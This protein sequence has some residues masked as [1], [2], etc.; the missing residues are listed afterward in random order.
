MKQGYE[1]LKQ[2]TAAL[3]DNL[4]KLREEKVELLDNFKTVQDE[5]FG[6]VRSLTQVTEQMETLEMENEEL[7]KENEELKEKLKRKYMTC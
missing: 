3:E 1:N 5:R 4:N 2:Q 6:F 7:K